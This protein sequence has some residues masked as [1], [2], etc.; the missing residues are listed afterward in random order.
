M[1][2]QLFK[3]TKIK[4]LVSVQS[5]NTHKIFTKSD[6]ILR[7]ARRKCVVETVEQNFFDV[8]GQSLS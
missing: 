6:A 1:T 8:L 7:L 5:K 4:R 3:N 2:V